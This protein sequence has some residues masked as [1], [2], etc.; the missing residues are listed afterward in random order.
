MK[1]KW[2]C[3]LLSIVMLTSPALALSASDPVHLFAD[4]P[5]GISADEVSQRLEQ[6]GL[7]GYDW[8]EGT[9]EAGV[10]I[11]SND[12]TSFSYLTTPT[13]GVSFNFRN[14]EDSFVFDQAMI[15]FD[16]DMTGDAATYVDAFISLIKAVSKQFGAQET[17]MS[18]SS[19]SVAYGSVE[20]IR[21]ESTVLAHELDRNQLLTLINNSYLSNYYLTFD[22]IDCWMEYT[23]GIGR[24]V[25]FMDDSS[26]VPP[27]QEETEQ[28]VPAD[29]VP[30]DEVPADSTSI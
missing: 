8:L 9:T 10:R 13:V 16:I 25:L 29:E 12:S 23:Q 3:L 24:L 4:I 7:F 6:L 5:F 20:L 19:E 2:I 1:N 28:D 26:Y 27:A 11:V 15:L 17:P 22:N 18:L 21:S 30:A 14:Q